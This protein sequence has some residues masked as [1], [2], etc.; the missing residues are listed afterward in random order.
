M[1]IVTG[2]TILR[3]AKGNP[4][5][6]I[7]HRRTADDNEAD[8]YCKMVYRAAEKAWHMTRRTEMMRAAEGRKGECR[9]E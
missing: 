8:K 3:D 7:I 4:G 6:M 2:C 1:E 9:E 5:E